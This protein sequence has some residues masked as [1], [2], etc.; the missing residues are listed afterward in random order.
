MDPTKNPSFSFGNVNVHGAFPVASQG[1]GAKDSKRVTIMYSGGIHTFQYPVAL[2][3]KGDPERSSILNDMVENLFRQN[4]CNDYVHLNLDEW[5]VIY[6]SANSNSR[7][8]IIS[9][10]FFEALDL[11]NQSTDHSSQA[12]PL[13]KPTNIDQ[14]PTPTLRDTA[15]SAFSKI[16]NIS[17]FTPSEKKILSL[18]VKDPEAA[19]EKCLN[20]KTEYLKMIVEFAQALEN[21]T[22]EGFPKEATYEQKMKMLDERLEF[23]TNLSSFMTREISKNKSDKMIDQNSKCVKRVLNSYVELQKET[24][25]SIFPKGNNKKQV[26]DDKNWD[27]CFSRTI[28]IQQRTDGLID[29]F[30]KRKQEKNSAKFMVTR[31]FEINCCS[32]NEHEI[33]VRYKKIGDGDNRVDQYTLSRNGKDPYTYAIRTIL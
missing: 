33:T 27:E 19:L 22:K 10:N 4:S 32:V 1:T 12:A 6:G 11:S 31:R 16:N 3:I 9:D 5:H 14:K 25:N 17:N 24:V 29:T 30:Y 13:S 18:A 7:T 21:Y 8:T 28:A 2:S 20:P 26:E 15:L 23:L